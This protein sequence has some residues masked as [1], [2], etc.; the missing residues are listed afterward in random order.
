M[1]DD[2]LMMLASMIYGEAA[3]EDYDT[4][5][6]VGSSA[7]NRLSSGKSAEFGRNMPEVL[8]KGYYAVSKNSPMFQQAMTR[9]FPDKNSEEKFKQ[10]LAISSGLLKGTIKP[11]SGL[12]YFKPEEIKKLKKNKKVFDFDKVK[13]VGKTGKYEVF[14][15]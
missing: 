15:Y 5:H 6:M 11:K 14:E 1:S 8:Y 2:E 13:S 7:I 12:F 3:S 4:M 9:K 10:A